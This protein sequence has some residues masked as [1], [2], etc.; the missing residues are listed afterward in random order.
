MSETAV[1]WRAHVGGELVEI[2][3]TIDGVR[4]ALACDPERLAEF[5]AQL[6]STPAMELP[7]VLAA[8]ALPQQAWDETDA[9]IERLRA[10]DFSGCTPLDD[11]GGDTKVSDPEVA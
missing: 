6:G 11:L 5:E 1:T 8:Y 2:P 4:S 3:A 9:T 10:G 7:A